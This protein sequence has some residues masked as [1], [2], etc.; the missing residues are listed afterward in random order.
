M[1]INGNVK[2][3]YKIIIVMNDISDTELLNCM[4]KNLRKYKFDT[5]FNALILRNNAIIVGDFF[6]NCFT[7]PKKK[8]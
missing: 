5:T 8:R 7:E 1:V 2:F 6:I 3:I 4:I